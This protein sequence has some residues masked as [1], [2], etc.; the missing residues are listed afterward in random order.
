MTAQPARHRTDSSA[1]ASIFWARDL[2]ADAPSSGRPKHA[3]RAQPRYATHV[4]RV[5]ALAV[6][7]GIGFAVAHS[8][9]P[10]AYAETDA[11]SG[12]SSSAPSSG[13]ASESASTE[14][15]ETRSTERTGP[16][17]RAER[18]EARSRGAASARDTADVDEILRDRAE[19]A[20]ADDAEDAADTKTAGTGAAATAAVEV[21]DLT[22][23]PAAPSTD[24]DDT[25]VAPDDDNDAP[26]A[27]E[28]TAT[29]TATQTTTVREALPRRAAARAT[30]SAPIAS[31]SRVTQEIDETN[32]LGAVMSTAL[33]PLL[34]TDAPVSNPITDAI[35]AYVRR[36]INHTFFNKAPV[37]RSV[38]TEQIAT[39]Q[40]LI[41]I[42]AYDPNGDR[43][44]YEIVQPEGGFVFR[45]LLTG[46]FVYTPTTI[47][48]GDPKPVEFKII[49]R[50]DADHL[51]GTLGTIQKLLHSVA[52]AFG[53]AEADN[54]T[55]TIS[56]DVGP[57]LQVPP[58]LVAIGSLPY[59]LGGDPTKLLSVAE[60]VDLDSESLKRAVLKFT[61][62]DVA[63]D[64]LHFTD[65]DDIKGTWDA[66]NRTLTLE[67]DASLAAYEAALKAVTFSA[68]SLGVIGRTVS[69]SLVDEHNMATLLPATV[70]VAVLPALALPP[71]LVAL[72]GLPYRVGDD[73]ARLLSLAEIAD[74]DSANLKRIVLKI[75]GDGR[76]G[77]FLGYV[78]PDGSTITGEWS[79]ADSTLTLS[80]VAT[81][82]AYEAAL[83]AVT[84]GATQA[85]LLPR[86]ISITL[87]DEDDTES[88][89]PTIVA[90]GVID[91]PELPLSLLPVGL[92]VYTIGK[93]GVR[94]VSS[95]GIVNADNDELKGATVTIETARMSG[96]QLIFSGTAPAGIQVAQTNDYTLTISGV[97]S[98]EQYEQIFKQISFSAT[99]LGITRSVTF[100][101]MEVDGDE[102]LLPGVVFVNTLLPLPPTVTAP[103]LTSM[104]TLGKRGVVVAPTVLIG[105]LDSTTLTKATMKIGGLNQSGDKLTYAGIPGNPITATW[106]GDTLT[107]QGEATIEQYRAALESVTFQA[108]GGV[109]LIRVVE[110]HVYDDSGVRSLVAGSAS[111]NVKNPDRPTLVVTGP[112]LLQFPK[113]KETVRPISSAT[114]FDTDSTVLHGASVKITDGFTT[115]DTL[116]FTGIAGNPITA[117]FNSS[118]REL[119][120]TGTATLAQY[121]AALEAVTFRAEQHGA[122]FLAVSKTRTLTINISDDSDLSSLLPG[123]VLVTIYK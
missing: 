67:G 77:D 100:R 93:P 52:K 15:A 121:K 104:Y 38:T 2:L 9:T 22:G 36:L 13:T 102:T 60:I 31:A 47:V 73:P 11:D 111:V 74:S 3:R 116:A 70:V 81:K 89:L 122:G 83:K 32:V 48:T 5:G 118:T 41:D 90:F 78:K 66:T 87:T 69:I 49:V 109:G 120:L 50:D 101:A 88:A 97:G 84:F 92:P 65:T 68:T 91:V 46:K 40:V 72:P 64:A 18:A 34:D 96:D 37:V 33:S 26:A 86:A 110:I 16:R 58:T 23:T 106:S 1:N 115:G 8:A 61:L 25:A 62:G 119:T 94:L 117:T 114:I 45:E 76:P 79:A 44:T 71:A 103:G 80:G 63:G 107:L 27:T 14:R 112:S 82:A 85:G 20:L 105:D 98:I 4:G 28:E 56:F 17:S 39:G 59:Q 19:A 24:P 75:V 54:T 99:Q 123:V 95:V 42:D 12:T 51:P 43:L 30:A 7:L 57:I 6:S 35:F 113:A 53:L 21:D 10:V 108:G 29:E 55:Q